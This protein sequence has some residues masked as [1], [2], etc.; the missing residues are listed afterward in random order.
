MWQKSYDKYLLKKM[1]DWNKI[2]KRNK[3]YIKS[4]DKTKSKSENYRL[5]QMGL[6]ENLTTF[7]G[8]LL[9]TQEDIKK[10]LDTPPQIQ[11]DVP[12][13]P[14][15]EPPQETNN[16]FIIS[17]IEDIIRHFAN[18]NSDLPASVRPTIREGWLFLGSH[19]FFFF[20]RSPRFR[21]GPN[22]EIYTLTQGLINLLNGNDFNYTTED[23]DS[24]SNILHSSY[25]AGRPTNRMKQIDEELR[26]ATLDDDSDLEFIDENVGY[27][28]RTINE[29]IDSFLDYEGEGIQFLPDDNEELLKRLTILT[30]AATH[31][32][33]SDYNEI[34]AILKR[35]LEKGVISKNDYLNV[36]KK[37]TNYL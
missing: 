17:S 10:K 5:Q 34:H 25:G 20:P 11:Y 1:T 15:I 29:D 32:H 28:E 22:D 26:S 19:R 13:L 14:Q 16:Q 31:G 35:L 21:I 36:Y 9:K 6:D 18:P 23:L 30:E 37:W 3:E 27:N 33:Q 7:F 4:K 24:Y 8:P 2:I 12:P